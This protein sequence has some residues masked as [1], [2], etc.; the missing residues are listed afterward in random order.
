MPAYLPSTTA[1]RALDAITRLGSV[2]AAATELNLTRGAVSHQIRTLEQCVGF[3]LTERDGRGISLTQEGRQYAHEVQN[4][5]G[6][7]REAA[8]R[9]QNKPLAGRL[10]VSCNPG[11]AAYWLCHHIGDFVR[12]YPEVQLH[13]IAPREIGD[14]SHAEAD[15]FI[16][17]GIGDWPGQWVQKLVSLS[18]FPVCSPRL[19]NQY[20]GLQSVHELGKVP[21]LHMNDHTDWRVW[22]ASAAACEVDAQ[23]GLL[24]TDA[25]W[26]QSACIAA[27][28]V[29]IGDN[30]ISSTA[31]QSGLL[32]RPFMLTIDSP[33][34]YWLVAHPH[35]AERPLVQAFCSWL[36]GKLA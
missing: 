20:G 4:L 12:Q 6:R 32:V 34:S 21:L 15:L 3:A 30:L 19:L 16:A 24:F 13:L 35:K 36:K 2:A 9:C 27:Q 26:A 25:S 22:L 18:L 28:G 1:L 33:R 29:C 5:L 10:T 8:Q 11:F 14:T 31:L 17:F 7:L 23:S